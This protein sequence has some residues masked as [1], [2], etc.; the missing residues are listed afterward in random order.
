MKRKTAWKLVIAITAAAVLIAIV[1]LLPVGSW[2]VSLVA[3]VRDAGVLGLLVYSVAFVACSV[4]LLPTLELYVAAGMIWGTWL[5]AAVTTALTLVSALIAFGL[6]RTGLRPWIERRIERNE[7]LGEIDQG[8]ADRSFWIAFL[9]RLSPV[10]PFGPV[11]YALAATKMSLRTYVVTALIGMLPDNIL[12]AYAGSL[13]RDVT[14]LESVAPGGPWKQVALW[15]GIA[16][17]IGA[18]VLIGIAVKR[19]LDRASHR[20]AHAR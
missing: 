7:K 14:E 13:L 8:I 2:V 18:S 1:T 12:I 19:A 11:N 9:L 10:V 6:T 3:W 15:A 16:A 4:L 5:G 17:T 20:H